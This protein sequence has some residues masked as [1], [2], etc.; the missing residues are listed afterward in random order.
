M[1]HVFA[2][3]LRP[4]VAL[5]FAAFL[6]LILAAPVNLGEPVTAL[7]FTRFYNRIGWAALAT[8]LVMY[9]PPEHPRARQDRVDHFEAAGQA[10]PARGSFLR[11]SPDRSRLVGHRG[12]PRI[13]YKPRR[14]P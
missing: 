14:G 12:V 1:A 4:V 10:P 6:L 9:L 2:T 3:R 7:S 13:V 8:L 11:A 5:P